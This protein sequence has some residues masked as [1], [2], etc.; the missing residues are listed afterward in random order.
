MNFSFYTCAMKD[1]FIIF[2]FCSVVLVMLVM[3]FLGAIKKSLKTAPD[4]SPVDSAQLQ[5][6]Q[7]DRIRA[8]Q[9]RQDQFMRNHRQKMRDA[10]R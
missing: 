8:M 6:I 10:R 1:G 4:P 5:K 7:S 3:G 9:E 2:V